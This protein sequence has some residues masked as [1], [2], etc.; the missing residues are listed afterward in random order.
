MGEELSQSSL[1]LHTPQG[2]HFLKTCRDLIK[3]PSHH[4]INWYNNIFFH[5]N[6]VDKIVLIAQNIM[7][8]NF[9]NL[10]TYFIH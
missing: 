9:L 2:S 3:F 1:R 8:I 4:F 7:D 10:S 6:K 5:N